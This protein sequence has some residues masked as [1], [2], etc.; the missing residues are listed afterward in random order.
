M[1]DFVEQI[2]VEQTYDARPSDVWKAITERDRMRKWFFEPMQEF[3]PKV[4]FETEFNVH[5]EGV[6]YPHVW[7]VTEVIPEKRIAYGWRYGGYPGDSTVVWEMA[8][9]G[10][11]TKLTLTHTWHE[12]FPTDV[13]VFSR[14]SCEAGW[15]YFLQNS[16]KSYLSGGKT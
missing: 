11:G 5:C 4:G 2:I 6:D 7:N 1:S 14:N 15:K 16:L 13:E 12:A 8:P 9:A 3:Q 10:G